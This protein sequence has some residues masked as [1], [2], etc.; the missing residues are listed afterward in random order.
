MKRKTFLLI[1]SITVFILCLIIFFSYAY[2]QIANCKHAFSCFADCAG[3]GSMPCT[4]DLTLLYTDCNDYQHRIRKTCYIDQ[5]V[6]QCECSCSDIPSVQGGMSYRYRRTDRYV[7]ET[8]GCNPNSCPTPTPTPTPPPPPPDCPNAIENFS[9]NACPI[10]FAPDSSGYYCCQI[11]QP[12]GPQSVEPE[13]CSYNWEDYCACQRY[14]GTWQGWRCLCWAESPV[15]I[16]VRGNG[17]NLTSAS[18]GVVFDIRGDGK[19]LNV[20]WTAADSDDAFLTLDR[21]NN[22]TIDSGRE[23]FGNFS[24]QPAPPSGEKRNGFLALAEF[25]KPANGGNGDG[26]IDARD[27]VFSRLRLWQDVNRNGVSEPNELR[28]L[29]EFDVTAIELNYRESKRTDEFGNQFRYRAKVWD[30][31]T[32]R[33]GVGRWAWDVFLISGE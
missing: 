33:S 9:R 2:S 12:C 23:L 21:D 32:G 27:T 11:N 29:P 19:P 10:D 17:F 18:P 22:G 7:I 8:Y 30:S 4:C 26:G 31:R 28:A 15:I 24:P 1:S 20:A 3:G 25:D 5:Y 6:D 16:D 13:V 14:G